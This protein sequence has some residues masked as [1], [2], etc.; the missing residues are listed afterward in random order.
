MA[1]VGGTGKTH[2]HAPG[3]LIPVGCTE[4]HERGDEVA[5]SRV[6]DPEGHA[7]GLGGFLD[8]PQLIPHPLDDRSRDVYRTLY[9]VVR[10]ILG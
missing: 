3:V 7:L 2:D 8:Y 1:A 9:G 4:T 10:T 6:L 5:T